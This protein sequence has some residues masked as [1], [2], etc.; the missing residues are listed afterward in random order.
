VGLVG[1][2]KIFIARF[3]NISHP[4]TS[5][6]NKVIKFEWTTKCEEKFNSLK[7]LL[8]SAPILNIFYP[9]ENFGVCTDACKEGIVGFLTLNQYVISYES[10][11]IK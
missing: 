9:N 11:N 3:S 8:T 6:K 7:E 2:Y 1:Y 4:I 10:I 5:L